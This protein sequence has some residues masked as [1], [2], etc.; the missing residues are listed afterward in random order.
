MAVTGITSVYDF[1]NGSDTATL[2]VP[3]A[4]STVGGAGSKG[5]RR[6]NRLS[7]ADDRDIIDIVSILLISGFLD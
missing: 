3:L 4:S 6:D 1:D 2:S 5:K 7:L